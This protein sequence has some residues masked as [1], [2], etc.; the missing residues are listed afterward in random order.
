MQHFCKVIN[1][2]FGQ[3]MS[4]CKKIKNRMFGSDQLIFVATGREN[5]DGVDSTPGLNGVKEAYT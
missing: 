5:L 2:I 1:F 4:L 3:S